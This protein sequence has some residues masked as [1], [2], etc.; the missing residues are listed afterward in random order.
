M[1]VHVKQ[2]GPQNAQVPALL[3]SFPG[4]DFVPRE[5][6]FVEK[7]NL[8]GRR[9][10]AGA[11]VITF[12]ACYVFGIA[13]FGLLAGIG[14]GWLPASF[15]AWLAITCIA[16]LSTKLIWKTVAVSRYLS[17]LAHSRKAHT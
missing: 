3:K 14:L 9:I 12:I 5:L 17:A 13:K 1:P 8:L 10:G 16:P 11:A 2:G 6:D 4:H 7:C 15:L